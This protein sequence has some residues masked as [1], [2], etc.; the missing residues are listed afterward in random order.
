MDTSNSAE[1]PLYD[2]PADKTD[3]AQDVFPDELLLEHNVFVA[4]STTTTSPGRGPM[5]KYTM[6]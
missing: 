6:T 5:R 2:V 1:L 4:H 3:F